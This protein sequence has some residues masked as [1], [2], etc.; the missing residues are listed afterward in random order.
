MD[1]QKITAFLIGNAT[2]DAEIKAAKESDNRYGDFRLAV[3]NRQRET[4]YFPV[5]CF[6]KLAESV[7]NVKKGTKLFVTG[8]LEFGSFADEEGK[9]RVTFRVLAD[10]YRILNSGRRETKDE[11]AAT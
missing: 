3:K 4:T 10:T 1:F 9:K 2:H 5:R 6:G 7:T 8:E 11:P